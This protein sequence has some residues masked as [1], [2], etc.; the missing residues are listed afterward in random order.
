M[1]VAVRGEPMRVRP[2]QIAVWASVSVAGQLAWDR[3]TPVLPALLDTGTNHNFSIY[4]SQLIRWAGMRPE[5]LR[6]LGHARVGG[7]RVSLNAATVWI[8]PNVPGKQEV[9][10]REPYPLILEGGIALLPDEGT[11]FPHLPLLGLRALTD[12]HLRLAIDG[13]HRE[14]SLH[15]PSWLSD[16]LRMLGVPCY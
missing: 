5:L 1:T 4:H 13:R 2:Y 16:M 15:T 11:P 12:N 3:R 14:V 8:H 10:N 6:V 9:S 7:K